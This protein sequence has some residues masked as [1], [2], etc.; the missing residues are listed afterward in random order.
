M[1]TRL[2]I[3]SNHIPWNLSAIT[4]RALAALILVGTATASNA[5]ASMNAAIDGAI[6][7]AIERHYVVG[8]EV[9]VA[10]G[11]RIVYHRQAGF[12]DRE[13][14]RPVSKSQ[15]FRLAS[16]SK[17]YVTT[18][19]VVLASRGA[20]NLDDPVTRYLPDFRPRLNGEPVPITI[21]QLMTH[22]AGLSYPFLEPPE[23]PYRKLHVST[24]LDQ[25]GLSFATELDRLNE[26]G[27]VYQPGSAWRYS[28]SIDVLGAVVAKAY[29]APL[30][31]AVR[32]LVLAPLG[33]G[34]TG[35]SVKRRRQ[36]AVPYANIGD[37]LVR[38]S[39]PQTVSFPGVG[40]LVF[41]PCR[42]W[43]ARSYPSGG[44]GMVGSASDLERLL[45]TL[46]R[47]GRPLFDSHYTQMMTT[48]QIDKL[49][50]ILGPGWGF[51]FGGAVLLD[52][53]AAHSPQALGTW[54]W[55]GA[56][57]HNWFVDPENDLTV[58]AFT[59][60][61]PGGDSGPYTQDLRDSIYSALGSTRRTTVIR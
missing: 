47:G 52:P 38:M 30:P 32:A 31:E 58:V 61:A 9:V 40:D 22:T 42:I 51:G 35:F 19:A 36:L 11:G 44:A 21:R 27:L 56:Y 49:T 1:L 46:R 43:D 15:I 13:S 41:S 26:A 6:S 17:I 57:G 2:S 12:A 55:T 24:G 23:S 5:T 16:V 3:E 53:L 33:L 4:W 7:R 34:D 10:L 50:T 48:N 18:A 45:E 59:N 28:L 37:S 54:G 25:P 60:S 20:I 8:T 29:G 39:C 14:K